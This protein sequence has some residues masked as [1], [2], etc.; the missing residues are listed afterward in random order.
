MI[1][2][3]TE[4]QKLADILQPNTTIIKI[5]MDLR[6]TAN[7]NRIERICDKNHKILLARNRD[8]SI[9]NVV[10]NR[11]RRHRRPRSGNTTPHQTTP[12][13]TTRRHYTVH[14]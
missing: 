5:G 3:T 2:T 6:T 7:R 13:N 10:C 8:D 9:H 1:L 12:H 11:N 14:Y 4:E